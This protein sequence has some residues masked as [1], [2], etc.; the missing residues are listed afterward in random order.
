MKKL[1]QNVLLVVVSLA[2]SLL[3][4]EIASR[5]IYTRPWYQR[6]VDAQIDADWTANIHRNAYGLRGR[7]LPPDKTPNTTRI[8]LLGDSFTFGSGVPNDTDIFAAL[9]EQKMNA[10]LAGTGSSVEV[11]NGGI[12]GSQTGDWVDLLQ[13]VGDSYQP[14]VIVIVF[15]LRDGTLTSSMGSFFGP[16][17]DEIVSQ[18]QASALYQNVYLYRLYKDFQDRNLISDSYTQAMNES[19]FGDRGQTQ[20][21]RLAQTN[22]RNLKKMGEATHAKVGLIIFPV[23]ADF[24]DKYPFQKIVDEVARFGRDSQ[25]PTLNLLPA[26]KGRN[27]SDLWVSPLNQHPNAAGHEIAA[28]AMLEWVM[29]LV[30]SH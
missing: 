23:L 17:R 5:V 24:S 30:V 19:Y 8:L 2:F 21:W 3:L 11:L 9:L 25:L 15:F 29:Q 4:V 28:N 7:D 6:L 16:I 10:Q 22:M 14:D 27:A 13:K 18:N 20:E 1:A 26:F 12:P